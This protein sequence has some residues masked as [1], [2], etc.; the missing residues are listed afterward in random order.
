MR[1]FIKSFGYAF[2]GIYDCIKGERNFRIHIVV[3]IAV[4][5]FSR[6]YDVTNS[7]F[8]AIVLTIFMVLIAETFNTSIESV[9]DLISRD[10]HELAKIAKDTAAAAVLLSAVGSVV[11]AVVVFSDMDKLINTLV[12]LVAF[13]NIIFTLVYVIISLVF[14]FFSKFNNVNNVFEKNK[15]K[16]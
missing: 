9:V 4:L 13:P 15:D 3:G 1:D 12:N 16:R 8:L 2:S 11:V 10:K 14:V 6:M 7:Q 5:I